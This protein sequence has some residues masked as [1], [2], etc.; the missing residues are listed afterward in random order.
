MLHP[1][2]M[3]LGCDP[4]GI[5]YHLGRYDLGLQYILDG[6]YL[7]FSCYTCLVAALQAGIRAASFTYN[8]YAAP[9]ALTIVVCQLLRQ[10]SSNPQGIIR[11]RPVDDQLRLAKSCA[12]SIYRTHG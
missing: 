9:S 12:L 2:T 5:V 11:F 6:F 7:D 4:F 3:C 10:K 1:Y 8:I